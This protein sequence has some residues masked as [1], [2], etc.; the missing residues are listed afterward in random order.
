MIE[1]ENPWAIFSTY[2]PLN[3]LREK[4]W[5]EYT[6]TNFEEFEINNPYLVRDWVMIDM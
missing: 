4:I 5:R 3:T 1:S 6:N 2:T